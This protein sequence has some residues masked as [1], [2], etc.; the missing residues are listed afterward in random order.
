MIKNKENIYTEKIKNLIETNII[1]N[2]ARSLEKEKDKLI[3]NYNIGK[4][5]VNARNEDKIKYGNNYIKNLSIEL[6]RLYGKGYDYSNLQKM[7]KF[8]TLFPNVGSLTPHFITWTHMVKIITIKNENKRNYYINLVNKNNLSVRKLKE[9]IKNQAYERLDN[10]TKENIEIIPEDKTVQII[11]FIKDPLLIDLQELKE[12][13]LNEKALKK[14]ILKEIE[15]FLLELGIGFSFVGS[16][17][18]IKIGEKFHYIDLLFFNIEQ[19]C[20]VA[21]ELKIKDLKKEDIGQLQFY[22]NYIDLEIK[23]PHHNP[24]IGILICKKSDKHIEKYLNTHNIKITT[25]KNKTSEK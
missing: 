10:K 15:K 20:Y 6:T 2:K 23:K 21:V 19:N 9:E 22:I 8:Y 25:Y 13:E 3:T 4:E 12:K 11:D 16:E 5:I 7:R 1:Q 17:K 14:A 24:T 18:K